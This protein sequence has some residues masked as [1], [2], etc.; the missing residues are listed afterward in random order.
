[1]IRDYIHV[2]DVAKAYVQLAGANLEDHVFN[3]GSGEGHSLNDIL[4][5]IHEVTG[6][7]P[8]VRYTPGRP[9]DVPANVLD[10]SRICSAVPWKPMIPLRTG[11]ER[12]WGWVQDTVTMLDTTVKEGILIGGW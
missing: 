2:S 10:I 7:T 9:F 1:M 11:I 8:W 6:R 12:T 4:R 5:L 3:V